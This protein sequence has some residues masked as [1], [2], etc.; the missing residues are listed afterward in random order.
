MEDTS[1]RCIICDG[2]EPCSHDFDK[3]HSDLDAI[4]KTM[5]SRNGDCC[6]GSKGLSE[7]QSEGS[8]P[9][10]PTILNE[11]QPHVTVDVENKAISIL[12][13][14]VSYYADWITGEGADMALYR[15][16]DGHRVVGARFPL[17]KW[18]G[19]LPV[20]ILTSH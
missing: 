18:N 16:N 10:S 5:G 12:L 1:E 2:V 3:M 4:F 20:D 6:S 8:I 15:A 14:D 11:F 13:E 9:S 17:R 7:S 19:K